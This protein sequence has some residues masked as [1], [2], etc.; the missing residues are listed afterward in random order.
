MGFFIKGSIA[1]IDGLS[2]PP[3]KKGFQNKNINYLYHEIK[4]RM[5]NLEK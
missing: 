2:I 1:F 4:N 5:S 3:K